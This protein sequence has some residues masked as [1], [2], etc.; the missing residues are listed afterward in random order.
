MAKEIRG[1]RTRIGGSAVQTAGPSVQRQV[2]NAAI[3]EIRSRR[4]GLDGLNAAFGQFFG[5]LSQAVDS[6]HDGI[7]VAEKQRILQE[8]D[9]QKAQATA[10]FFSGR[11]AD[12]ALQGDLDYA[13]TYTS[14]KAQR[15]GYDASHEFDKWYRETYAPSNPHG[16]LI[17]ARDEWAK[18]QF[19]G[20]ESD[21]EY[22][23][24]ALGAFYKNTES[25]IATHQENGVRLLLEKGLSNL[26]AVIVEEAGAGNLTPDSFIGFMKKAQTLDPR[27]PNE[28][29]PR[30]A[31]AVLLAVHN[32][33]DKAM[34]I[35]G[36][37]RAPNTGVNGKSFEESFPDAF[38]KLE[39]QSIVELNNVNTMAA[40]YAYRGLTERAREIT[41]STPMEEVGKLL[42]DINAT[43]FRHGGGSQAEQLRNG[44]HTILEK[45]AE[46]QLGVESVAHQI[47]NET[48]TD[49]DDMRK[50]FPEYLKQSGVDDIMTADHRVVSTLFVKSQ[51]AI[52]DEYK[53][54]LSNG[55]KNVN[56]RE[57]QIQSAKILHGIYTD[58]NMAF[59]EKFLNEDAKSDLTFLKTLL[60]SNIGFDE[61]VDMM[62]SARR[63]DGTLVTW[64]QV[65]GLSDKDARAKVQ[66]VLSNQISKQKG[67]STWYGGGETVHV[68][69]DVMRRLESL[70]MNQFR[71]FDSSGLTDWEAALKTAVE[72]AIS[73]IDV[74]PKN[75]VYVASFNGDQQGQYIDNGVLADRIPLAFDAYNSRTKERVNTV[76][77][78]EENL[79]KLGNE[80]SWMF[81]NGSTEMVSLEPTSDA[82]SIGGLDVYQGFNPISFTP[83]QEVKFAIPITA[84]EENLLDAREFAMDQFLAGPPKKG[85]PAPTHRTVKIPE[86]INQLPEAIGQLPEGF[87][88]YPSFD[89][90]TGKKVFKL[91]YRPHFGGQKGKTLADQE[92]DFKPNP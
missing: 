74:L 20:A 16:D 33:K 13:Q 72:G 92:R 14:L 15:D 37:L 46:A 54:Q 86:D 76:G 69:V 80:Q 24:Q 39:A 4:E 3:P 18:N 11:Q 27:N 44:I 31:K 23:G 89:A 78:F 40:E 68:P 91:F 35:L 63:D 7:V 79:G 42:N 88:F 30:V 8:N 58:R 34:S 81:E 55:L 53:Y 29:A 73:R 87:G 25:L 83:G 66:S 57:R 56:N 65:T 52:G 70:G 41:N 6:V 1:G 38:A 84:P 45:K 61:A 51:G 60:D 64:A 50:F 85:T 71:K 5:Q 21:P 17:A 36:V 10:D 47:A 59:A 48:I 12:E 9:A 62:N 2:V 90:T 43:E 67:L 28:A 32:N 26:E 49:T 75:G 22:Q 77:I 82:A 19:A